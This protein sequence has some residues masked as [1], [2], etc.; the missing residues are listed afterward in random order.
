[1][2]ET[3]QNHLPLQPSICEGVQGNCDFLILKDKSVNMDESQEYHAKQ[4]KSDRKVKNPIISL[5]CGI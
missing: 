5:I 3:V 2:S 1:M 4:N